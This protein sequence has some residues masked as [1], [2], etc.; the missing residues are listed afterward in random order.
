MAACTRSSSAEDQQQG[1][2]ASDAMTCWENEDHGMVVV[3][4]IAFVL[5][6]HN[7]DMAFF[8]VFLEAHEELEMSIRLPAQAAFFYEMY[9]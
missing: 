7:P 2:T 5:M 6:L 1:T 4:T 9:N 8:D 3:L